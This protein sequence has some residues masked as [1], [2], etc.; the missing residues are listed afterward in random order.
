MKKARQPLLYTLSSVSSWA[1]DTGGYYVLFRL[2]A[3]LL[4]PYAE[5]VCN[6]AARVISSFFNFNLNNALVFRNNTPYGKALLRY[7]CLAVPQALMSTLLLNLF[8]RLVGADSALAS[9]LVKIL[10]DGTLFVLSFFIQKLWVFR[11]KKP[12]SEQE[13]QTTKTT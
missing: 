11:D 4:G 3:A 9:T 7:Y 1:V 10:V 2:F 12:E 6:L 8:A 5:T 13:D